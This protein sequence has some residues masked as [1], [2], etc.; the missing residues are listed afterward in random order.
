M[1]TRLPDSLVR[2]G[3]QDYEVLEGIASELEGRAG[4]VG[5]L[6]HVLPG[7]L[8]DIIDNVIQTPRTGRRSYDELEKTEKTYIGTQVEIVLRDEL[9]LPKGRLDTVVLGHDVDIKHTMGNNWMIPTEALDSP[10]ILVAADEDRGV[11]YLGLIIARL[12]YLTSSQ[13]R[14][15]KR[16]V[17][18]DGF[19]H[20]RWIV[21]GVPYPPN[22]WRTIPQDAVDAIFQ[23]DTGNDRVCALFREVQGV[24]IARDIINAVAKQKDFMRRIRADGGRG[25]R[26]RLAREGILLLSGTY[27]AP[28]IRDLGLPIGDFV[29]YRPRDEHELT[30]ARA[31]GWDV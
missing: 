20:I 2:P 3:H 11:C 10:C 26:D 25:T 16:S 30:L 18:A 27:D 23:G 12:E 1:R 21:P 22:F 13:N 9:R 7:L 8:R 19:A 28:L 6:A 14:D 31:A 5:K 24:P 29:S 15:A 4:G 17:S